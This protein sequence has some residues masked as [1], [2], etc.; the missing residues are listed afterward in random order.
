M[1]RLEQVLAEY[2]GAL[3]RLV[4]AYERDADLQRDL[5]QE[6]RF[7]VWRALPSFRG[8]SS[9]RT[10]IYRV[11]HNRATTH[12]ARRHPEQLDL[13]QALE[14]PDTAPN[15]EQI[16]T[17]R[18]QQAELVARV[19]SL[20]LTLRQVATLA[21]EGLSNGE[22]SPRDHA[23]DEIALEC[24]MAGLRPIADRCRDHDL[25]G[26]LDRPAPWCGEPGLA[27]HR[28]DR[29]RRSAPLPRPDA[30]A[31]ENTP[32]GDR[33][34][35]DGVSDVR[36]NGACASAHHKCTRLSGGRYFLSSGFTLKAS[37]HAS[38]F[39]VG[40]TTRKCDGLCGL[41]RICRRMLA[42]LLLLRHTCA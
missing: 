18:W 32:R 42:S 22:I 11:A 3:R 28:R 21:L 25:R 19:A 1:N 16:A 30:D 39:R 31:V 34:G 27:D 29:L 20:P 41:E 24:T 33:V 10:F 5:L 26:L 8:Q 23:C 14:V 9:E 36:R 15:P 40:P 2:D 13:T 17:R 37:Y 38:T 12:A 7:A 4:A 6:I 35:I